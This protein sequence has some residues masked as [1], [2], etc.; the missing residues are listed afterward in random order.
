MISYEYENLFNQNSISKQ[1]SI[2]VY[3][4]NTL[5]TTITNADLYTEDVERYNPLCTE[6]S[7]KF[8]ACEASYIKFTVRSSVSTLKDR[9][10]VVYETPG[11]ASTPLQVGEYFVDTD[12]LSNDRA[13]RTITAYDKLYTILNTDMLVWYSELGLPKTMRDFRDAFFEYFGVTQVEKTLCND[14][15]VITE[16]IVAEQ[17]SGLEILSCILSGNG[18]LGCINNEGKFR[19]IDFSDY[20]TKAYGKK[21]RQ[22]SLIYEDYVI[23]PITALKFFSNKVDVTVG[24]TSPN[25]NMY[26][27]EDNFLFYDKPKQTLQVYVE[28][29]F[30]VIKEVPA[31]RPLTAETLGNPCVEVGDMIT[32][33][34]LE[35]NTISTFVLE[36]TEKGIQGL[37]DS[38]KVKGT[39]YYQYDLN[40]DNARIR[41]LWNNTIVLQQEMESARC[42]VYAQRNSIAYSNINSTNET[43]IISIGVVSVDSTIPVFIATIPLTMSLDGEVTFRYFLDGIEI[44][45][46]DS[47]TIY[48]TKGKQ[49]VTISTYFEM[50]ANVR[51]IF[52]VTA[53]T[54]YRE[55]VERQQTAKI[56]SLKDW[57]DNQS[58]SVEQEGDVISASFDYDYVE[59]DVDDTP[60]TASIEALTIRAMIFAS[61]LADSQNWDGTFEIIENPEIWNLVDL[62]FANATDSVTVATQ[63][64]TGSTATDTVNSW[65][66]VELT[67]DS[68]SDAVYVEM[69]TEVFRMITEAEDVL[70]TE[71]GDVFYTE[72]D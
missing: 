59:Q 11:N 15:M 62:T 2:Q 38:F 20:G 6:G 4:G 71:D 36:K 5:E 3:N 28:N 63:V 72:G 61:G 49:F 35:G 58:I 27:I 42:Y 65:A 50:E 51:K 18:C 60:P 41:R 23:Q 17:L 64:P 57:I 14:D 44:D 43:T 16:T 34:T 8:G 55:S 53:K 13:S 56:L 1:Y 25:A 7:L 30:N 10:L 32:F 29:I 70:V 24:D 68:A 9:R 39:Q 45:E 67:F 12:K 37:R 26:V 54:G 22:D 31:F 19:Y 33:K 69:H 40:S 52:S 47:D 48:L 66:L 21:Y 46:H